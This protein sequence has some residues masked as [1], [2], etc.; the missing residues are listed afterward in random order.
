M[1]Q[2]AQNQRSPGRSWWRFAGWS[3]IPLILLVPLIGRWP[4]TTGDFIFA[5]ILMSS[6]GLAFELVV[7]TSDDIA[8]RLGAALAIIGAFLTIWVNGAVGMVGS[9]DNPYNLLFLGIPLV[10][11][12]GAVMSLF[13]PASLARTMFAAAALQVLLGGI[14]LASD[15]RGGVFSIAFAAIWLMAGGLFRKAAV[16]E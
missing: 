13:K 10:A 4:W 1:E 7:R 14:G 16:E 15:P 12:T 9:E 8:Y 6:V 5:A 2:V 11:V 3:L